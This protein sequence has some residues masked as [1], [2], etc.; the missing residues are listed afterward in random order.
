MSR[1]LWVPGVLLLIALLGVQFYALRLPVKLH[2]PQQQH[3]S[4]INPKIGLHT[5][6]ADSA[7]E[8]YIEQSLQQVREMGG[9][10]IVDLFPWAYIQPRSP[11]GFDW[12]GSDMIIQHARRQGLQ[13]IA[14]LDIVPEWARPANSSDRYLD[15]EHY[16]DYASYVV[17]FLQRYRPFGVRHVIIWNEPNL[18]QEWGNRPPD[19]GAYAALLKVVYPRVKAAVPDALVLAAGLSPGEALGGHGEVRMTDVQFLYSLYQAR[20]A[21]F[22][23]LLAVHTYGNTSPPDNP[24]DPKVVDFR[25]VEV[26]HALMLAAGDTHKHIIITEG[27]WNDSVRWTAA[28]RPSQRVH[29]TVQA[30]QM[31]QRWDWLDAM[32]LWQLGLPQPTHTYQDNWGFVAS[33]GTP[34]AVYWAVQAYAR[35]EITHQ[36]Q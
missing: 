21:P 6:L 11:S 20:A 30:Y 31:A 19:P 25:R 5:R 8:H 18:A 2:L 17:A 1:R 34:K 26:L 36:A 4:S 32:C 27:G 23:D 7:D 10:W 33:D 13:V 14:R 15:P 35:P 24:P 16:V 9:S 12:S 3:V 22:F 29:W 28:V